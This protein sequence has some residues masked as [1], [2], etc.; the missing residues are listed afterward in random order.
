MYPLQF[1]SILY[2]IQCC[3]DS[4]RRENKIMLDQIGFYLDCICINSVQCLHI[5]H[6]F[7]EDFNVWY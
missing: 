3:L 7:T 2:S 5:L 1:F 4:L 6:L